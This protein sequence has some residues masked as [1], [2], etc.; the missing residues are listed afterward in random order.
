M[1]AIP[2]IFGL[3]LGPVVAVA[4]NLPIIP[5]ADGDGLW[6]LSEMQAA[7]PDLPQ[8]VFT[9]IEVNGDGSA[10][11]DEVQKAIADG[12]LPAPPQ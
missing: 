9:A 5:D 3:C 7:Y 6:S 8:D 12:L 2:L 10:V 4:Q 11:A 1:K